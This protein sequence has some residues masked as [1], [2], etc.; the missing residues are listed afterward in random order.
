[1]LK[2]NLCYKA[3]PEICLTKVCNIIIFWVGV[4]IQQMETL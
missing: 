2:I 4:R 1:M 3:K